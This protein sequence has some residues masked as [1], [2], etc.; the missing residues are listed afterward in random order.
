[1]SVLVH[2]HRNET[3]LC[4]RPEVFCSLFLHVLNPLF[5]RIHEV[6]TVY[7]ICFSCVIFFGLVSRLRASARNDDE[8]SLN[9]YKISLRSFVRLTCASCFL[10][11]VDGVD[12][13]LIYRFSYKRSH[14]LSLSL[15]LFS[16]S[17]RISTLS[18]LAYR[19]IRAFFSVTCPFF[20]CQQHHAH[21]L[22]I[23]INIENKE[24]KFIGMKI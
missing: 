19:K 14:S 11:H 5:L 13:D 2:S 20:E 23:R 24:N 22:I 4:L 18:P 8:E 6:S 17:K 3:L 7:P 15:S 1:M 9:T 21:Y 10:S 16:L 12:S